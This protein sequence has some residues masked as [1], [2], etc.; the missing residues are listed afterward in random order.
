MGF[1]SYVPKTHV[2]L[3]FD[4][5][6]LLRHI[7]PN[8]DMDMVDYVVRHYGNALQLALSHYND[9]VSGNMRSFYDE[10]Y[11]TAAVDE[12]AYNNGHEGSNRPKFLR[13]TVSES[14]II[15]AKKARY[16]ELVDLCIDTFNHEIAAY[17]RS[18]QMD[19][20]R[21]IYTV[22]VVGYKNRILQLLVGTDAPII[23]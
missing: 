3:T 7:S 6:Q 11:Y 10:A 1:T 22:R 13:R 2:L 12:E 17:L 20:A 14:G 18:I 8:D 21:Q 23:P 5:T 16:D 9:N 15:I 19:Q 4:S